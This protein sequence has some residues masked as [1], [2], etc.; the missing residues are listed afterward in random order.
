MILTGKQV[1]LGGLNNSETLLQ[2]LSVAVT[3]YGTTAQLLQV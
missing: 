1:P 2:Q 3:L